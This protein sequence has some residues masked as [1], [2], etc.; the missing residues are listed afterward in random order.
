[1]AWRTADGH[2]N[3]M[4][5]N[6]HTLFD[7]LAR[8]MSMH[9][10]SPLEFPLQ[11]NLGDVAI[12]IEHDEAMPGTLVVY[13]SLGVVALSRETEISRALL[14]ANLFW[15]GTGDAT[16]GVNS[17]TREAVIAYRVDYR[18]MKVE[19]LAALVE[20]FAVLSE[21]WR[22]FIEEPGHEMPQR[23]RR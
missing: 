16:I 13:R 19:G 23:H 7:E 11:L 18:E 17:E 12:A 2:I 1:M 5:T 9:L 15:S 22:R 3:T 21:V 14:E 6:L 10:P 20:Q 8:S 4:S